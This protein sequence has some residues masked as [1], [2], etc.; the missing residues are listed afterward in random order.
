MS[1]QDWATILV[2]IGAGAI[3]KELVVVIGK[4]LTGRLGQRRN[5]VDRAF[6][7]RDRE[8]SRRRKLEESLSHHRRLMNEAPCIPIE[9]IPPWPTYTQGDTP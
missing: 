7:E 9:S 8:A 1:A 5:E 2:A 4:A 6:R 3:F